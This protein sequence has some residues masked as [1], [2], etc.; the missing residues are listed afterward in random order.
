MV[1][2]S[3]CAEQQLFE[4]SR[5]DA[6]GLIFSALALPPFLAGSAAALEG[7]RSSSNLTRSDPGDHHSAAN[8]IGAALLSAWT[9]RHREWPVLQ[10]R[11]PR[12]RRWLVQGIAAQSSLEALH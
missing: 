4:Q 9:F 3:T 11:D 1:A 12:S 2:S 7:S 5:S 8:C 6:S 10:L